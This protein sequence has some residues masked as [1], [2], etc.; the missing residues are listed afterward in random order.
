MCFGTLAKQ[1]EDDVYVLQVTSKAGDT[2][3]VAES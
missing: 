2:H 1:S 3:R